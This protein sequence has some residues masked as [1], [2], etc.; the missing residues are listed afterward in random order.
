MEVIQ[1]EKSNLSLAGAFARLERLSA[2]FG[3]GHPVA[4]HGAGTSQHIRAAPLCFCRVVEWWR[5]GALPD[6]PVLIV[7][8]GSIA[9]GAS[10]F[11]VRANSPTYL[12][13]GRLS[14]FC[15]GPWT[16]VSFWP[17]GVRFSH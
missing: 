2:G 11:C 10:V 1:V 15:F 7:L 3:G 6:Q 4:Q 17:S 16:L 5:V 13:S 9:F 8:A 12:G 14:A